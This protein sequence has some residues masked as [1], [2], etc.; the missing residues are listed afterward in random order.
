MPKQARS[1]GEQNLIKILYSCPYLS[2][3]QSNSASKLHLFPY[4]SMALLIAKG[5]K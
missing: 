2:N 4:F 3:K 5:G 1:K